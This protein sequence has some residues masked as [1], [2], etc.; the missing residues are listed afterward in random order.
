MPSWVVPI[1][2][3]NA[4][5]PAKRIRRKR[6][7][8]IKAKRIRRAR[9]KRSSCSLLCFVKYPALPK[10]TYYAGIFCDIVTD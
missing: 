8:I 3:E 2:M 9:R 6:R 7:K 1:A 10:L 5:V 4:R